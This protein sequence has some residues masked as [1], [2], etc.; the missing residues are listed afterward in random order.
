MRPVTPKRGGGDGSHAANPPLS[1][2]PRRGPPETHWESGGPGGRQGKGLAKQQG[3]PEGPSSL[4]HRRNVFT[5]KILGHVPPLYNNLPS[6][7]PTLIP[8]KLPFAKKSVF[9][10]VSGFL[11]LRG[12]HVTFLGEHSPSRSP[13]MT[14]QGRG[15][16]WDQRVAA[17]AALPLVPGRTEHRPNFR[18]ADSGCSDEL[19]ARF[20]RRNSRVYLPARVSASSTRVT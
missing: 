10:W 14:M 8:P 12:S 4:G 17:N 19:S 13:T 9:S 7:S 18:A 20:V 3:A 2:W 6:L 5:P 16:V 1:A 15:R 11:A